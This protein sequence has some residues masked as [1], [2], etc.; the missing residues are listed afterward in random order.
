MKK[1]LSIVLM[2]LLVCSTAYASVGVQDDGTRQGV[3]TDLNF[4]GPTQTNDGSTFTIDTSTIAGD[5][6]FRSTLLAIGGKGASST[7]AS[8]STNLCPSALPYSIVLKSVGE[9][10]T[11]LD[12]VPGT[13]LQ[14]GTKG[15]ILVLEVVS[16]KSNGTWKV[17]PLKCTGFKYITFDTKGDMVTLWYVDDTVGWIIYSQSGV[18]VTMNDYHT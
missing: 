14:N 9:N 12:T 18:T 10:T 7:V 6:T 13:T 3:A 16:L 11:C 8:S 4:V 15:Q 5:M 17:A 2:A 1:L